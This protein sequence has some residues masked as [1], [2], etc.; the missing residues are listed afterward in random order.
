MHII[1]SI[2]II[3]CNKKKLRLGVFPRTIRFNQL[4]QF[5][6][7]QFIKK[8]NL[9]NVSW[10][11]NRGEECHPHSFSMLDADEFIIWANKVL[12]VK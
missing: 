9:A 10:G 1:Q 8:K 6:N 7:C 5:L 3:I 2:S 11:T 12:N 4:P